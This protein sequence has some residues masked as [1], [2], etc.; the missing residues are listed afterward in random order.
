MPDNPHATWGKLLILQSAP[1]S[2][3][4]PREE[5]FL[6]QATLDKV[7]FINC[8]RDR[9]AYSCQTPNTFMIVLPQITSDSRETPIHAYNMRKRCLIGVHQPRSNLCSRSD[10]VFIFN[11]YTFRLEVV[12]YRTNFPICP[13]LTM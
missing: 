2:I 12:S 3:Q 9:S 10:I 4:N 6:L 13:M 1:T 7:L 11:C 5:A 8:L